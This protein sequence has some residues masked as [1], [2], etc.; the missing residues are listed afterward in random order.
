VV[1]D[2]LEPRQWLAAVVIVGAT[3][4]IALRGGLDQ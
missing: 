2:R 1:G 4:A 3:A